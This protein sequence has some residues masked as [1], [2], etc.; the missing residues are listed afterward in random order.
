MR[1]GM[2]G[3][4]CGLHMAAGVTIR[5]GCFEDQSKWSRT[6]G[7]GNLSFC[8][9]NTCFQNN[10]VLL[11][12]RPELLGQT[13]RIMR[14]GNIALPI[15]CSLTQGPPKN[16]TKEQRGFGGGGQT[17]QIITRGNFRTLA[18]LCVIKWK[19]IREI[20]SLQLIPENVEGL[21]SSGASSECVL[22]HHRVCIWKT[23]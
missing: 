10:N 1:T 5:H 3:V 19:K 11:W 15:A 18:G 21:L 22:T 2:C 9:T 20:V 16:K 14:S 6:G 17:V 23:I 12:Q 8:R 13:W 4:G 7:P